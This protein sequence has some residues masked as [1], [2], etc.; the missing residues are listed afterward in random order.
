MKPDLKLARPIEIT[1]A[2][3]E[4]TDK[5]GFEISPDLRV[6]IW[7]HGHMLYTTP[8]AP[9]DARELAQTL[10]D[11]AAEREQ[12]ADWTPLHSRLPMGSA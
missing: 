8:L 1:L 12:R 6:A 4:D 9:S 2:R 10:L 7:A 5:V 11:Y 3:S